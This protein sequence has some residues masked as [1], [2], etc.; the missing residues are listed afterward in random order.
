M[1]RDRI[2]TALILAPL[3]LWLVLWAQTPIAIAGFT[4]AILIGAWEWAQFCG[5]TTLLTRIR[6]VLLVTACLF[7]ARRYAFDAIVL[8]WILVAALLWWVVALLW[9]ALAPERGQVWLAAIAGLAVLV[10]TWLALCEIRQQSNGS[11]LTLF[12]MVLIFSTDIGAYFAGRAF[13]R[14]KLAPKV[15][16]GK[17][18]E[19]VI[20]G[21]LAAVAVAL[22]GAYWFRFELTAFLGLSA[23]VAAIS[24]VGDLTESMF[25]RHAGLK[26]SSKLLPGHGGMLDRIDS[27]TAAAP[28]FALGLMWLG[29]LR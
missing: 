10:P 29:A 18:W 13:G 16:P 1:L 8:R 20:G 28:V 21:L 2:I 5:L 3:L 24:I 23:A 15:S 4:V 22:V 9:L 17:T 19:G 6:Y 12:L 27:I 7:L 26:D 11:A 25:K 14:V